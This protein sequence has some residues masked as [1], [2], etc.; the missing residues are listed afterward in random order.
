MRFQTWREAH[1]LSLREVADLTGISLSMLSR[2]ES[3]DRQPSAL[4]KVRIARRLGAHIS[5]L[6]DTEPEEEEM[7]Q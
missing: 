2:I 1:R 6:F 5:E 4:L 7:A 3:G